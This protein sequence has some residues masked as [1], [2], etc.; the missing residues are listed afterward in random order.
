MGRQLADSFLAHV[1]RLLFSGKAPTVSRAK[2]AVAWT[3]DHVS[4]HNVGYVGGNLQLAVLEK[5]NGVWS[6][7]HADP[8]EAGQQMDLLEKHIASFRETLEPD[9]AAKASAVD[10]H[11]VLDNGDHEAGA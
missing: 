2:L 3:I 8:G 11:E 5:L 10:L 1:Y 7:H 9:A 4:K 6:A